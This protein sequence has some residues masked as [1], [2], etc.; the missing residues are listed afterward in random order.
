[1]RILVTGATGQI[2]SELT[3]VLRERYGGDAVI[4]AGHR[5]PASAALASSG[6]FVSLD[7]ANRDALARVIREHGIETVYHLAAVLSA[8]GEQHPQRAWDVHVNGLYNLLELARES[9]IRQIF[10]PS[11]IAVFGPRTPRDRTPQDTVLSPTTMYGVT[12]VT[13]ELL[14]DYYAHRFGLDIRGLRYPGIISSETPPGGGTTDY[15]VEMFYLAVEGKPYTCFVREDTML[16]MMFMPDCLQAALDLME[17]PGAKLRYRTYNISAMSFTA[18]ELAAEIRKHVPGFRVE[19][20]PDFRQ[21]IADSWPRSIDD[22]AARTDWG[23]KPRY[24]LPEMVVE[25]LAALSRRRA[26][27]CLYPT[28]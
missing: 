15:A 17:A 28:G 22:S 12:K 18:G 23:W 11:S 10:Y 16:P 13:G 3:L 9:G 19:Y 2:G 21:A 4:A 26:A 7:V 8:T 20:V 1:M 6:P 24:G 5:K 25:M 27:G 14:C